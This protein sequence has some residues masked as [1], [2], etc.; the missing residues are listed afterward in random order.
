MKQI[1]L[2]LLNYESARKRFPPINVCDKDGKPLF[3]WLVAILPNTEYGAIYDQLNLDEPWNSRH[4]TAAI[5]KLQ[6]NELRMPE[7]VPTAEQFFVELRGDR[8]AGHNLAEG[9]SD[10]DL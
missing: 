6:V 1:G 9:G 4:N 7:R 5:G 10:Q 8:W 3:S 2:G